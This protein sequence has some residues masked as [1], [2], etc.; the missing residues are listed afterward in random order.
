MLAGITWALLPLLLSS[1]TPSLAQQALHGIV[2]DAV[3]G[4]ALS[5][6]L[7][8]E[9][10]SGTTTS[11]GADGYYSL[12]L[13]VGP[14][15]VRWSRVGYQ[16][17][18]MELRIATGDSTSLNIRLVQS[19]ILIGEE[20]VTAERPPISTIHGLGA[21]SLLPAATRDLGGPFSDVFRALQSITGVTSNNE[22][23]SRFFVRGGASNENL[24]QLDGVQVLEP[25]HLKESPNTSLSAIN[26]DLLKQILFIPGGFSARYGDRL[27]SVLDMDYREGTGGKFAGVAELSL[28]TLG[29]TAE[30]PLGHETTGLVSARSTYSSYVERYIADG[31]NRHPSFF[32][33]QGILAGNPSPDVH[34]S[35]TFLISQDRTSG[36]AT[37]KYGSTLASVRADFTLSERTVLKSTLSSY[38]DFAT[39]S[40]NLPIDPQGVNVQSTHY[41]TT[42]QKARI[43][44]ESE[45]SDS[46]AVTSG[47]EF[48]KSIYNIAQIELPAAVPADSPS[49][50]G[51]DITPAL[52]SAFVENVYHLGQHLLINGGLR[53]DLNSYPAE[54]KM[55]PRFLAAYRF[56]S[57]TTLKTA[58]G[59][60]YQT[61]NDQQLLASVRA[62]LPP[63]HMQRA[64]HYLVGLEEP[65]RKDLSLRI[66]VYHKDLEELISYQ[67]LRSGEIIHSPRNDS[68]GRVDG[69]DLEASFSDERVFG[70]VSAAFLDAKE[71]NQYD[72][73]GWR[74]R[75][76]DQ[77][78][79]VTVVFE[80]KINEHLTANIRAYYGSG[81]AYGVDT[82]GV[83]I[84][85]VED[86]RLHYPDYKR[87][88]VRIQY[89]QVIDKVRGMIYIDIMNL[90]AQRNVL[91]FTGPAQPG[92]PLDFN[93]LLP[94]V[95]NVG[96]K[97]W[98]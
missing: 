85:G 35:A 90:F 47:F 96:I 81:F 20:V 84:T 14:Q 69:I 71:I 27:S 61:A 37:G 1:S 73:L 39:I 15:K 16:S 88:D 9:T 5:Q 42:L 52:A 76:N 91:S 40:W 25:F 83:S 49:R 33:V 24:M 2:K 72:N 46:Y 80:Y 57:G 79:T 87:A 4:E 51:L 86:K 54:M 93:H 65:L 70:W 97:I 17:Q 58:Y 92:Q 11:S 7:I 41:T 95:A 75:P 30:G 50:T 6:V 44:L 60:Y 18:T 45:I 34:A 29:V 12:L 32:D 48:R 31:L 43:S 55:S 66:D 22:M 8:V 10:G 19:T 94:M 3:T 77:A 89:A 21:V 82:P 78:K 64:V 23:S 28:V 98:I 13:P 36:V 74:F 53:G 62:G 26:T 59:I 56:R 38:T 67:R 68:R 63:Q